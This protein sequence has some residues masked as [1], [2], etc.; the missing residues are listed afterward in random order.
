M[1]EIVAEEK[2]NKA[3]DPQNLSEGEK[4]HIPEI[5]APESIASGEAFDVLVEVGLIPHVMEEKHYI[6]WIELYLNDK[7]IDRVELSPESKKAE[8]TFTVKIDKSLAGKSV[9]LR[10]LEH[11]NI[12]GSWEEFRSI[13]V[14]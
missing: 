7:K 8:A 5:T 3:V 10:A 4:K 14:S 2:I 12:H 9:N 6:E 13:K 11:C 1:A